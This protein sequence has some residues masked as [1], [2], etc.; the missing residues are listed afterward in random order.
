MGASE[1]TVNGFRFLPPRLAV[2]IRNLIPYEGFKGS[3][4]W[5]PLSKPVN[6]A[7]FALVT[8]A[9][10]S[11][12]TDPPF[13]MEREKKEPA[14][15]DRSF[16]TIPRNTGEKDINVN[17]LHV[18]TGYILQDLDVI[19]PLTRMKEFEREGLIGRLAPT[20]YSFYGFQWQSTDFLTEAIV[21]MC[22]TMHEEGVDAVI[23]TPACP[24]CCW[25]AGLA[26]RVLEEA[27]ISTV[28]LTPTPEFHNIVGIPRSAAI[29][30][31]Y[32]RPVGQVGDR[33]GQRE[34][35]LATL[36]VLKK[37]QKP[38][39]IRHLPFTWP[40]EPKDAKWHPP[41][42]SPLIRVYLDE[43]RQVRKK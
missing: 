10:I 20:S 17:H 37:A 12:K 42:M 33:E 3:I 22:K 14:W 23:L 35:L 30:F 40:E 24:F 27:R 16:R 11:L 19:L 39:E 1:R 32:G 36:R 9:G 5:T 7:T 13:D 43:I 2:W 29:E 8:T 15:G 18:N 21:P 38:G 41:E 25:S 26:A 31:P 28:V 6:E 4:P 34:V